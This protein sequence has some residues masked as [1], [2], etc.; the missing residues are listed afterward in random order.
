[1]SVVW[2][3]DNFELAPLAPREDE[4]AFVAPTV[5]GDATADAAD[6]CLEP[7]ALLIDL[8]ALSLTPDAARIAA[9]GEAPPPFDEGHAAIRERM[10]ERLHT[11]WYANL[12]E[13]MAAGVCWHVPRRESHVLR[14]VYEAAHPDAVLTVV[15]YPSVVN[16]VRTVDLVEALARPTPWEV[17]DELKALISQA[18]RTL[19]WQADLAAEVED[20][21]E[22]EATWLDAME[23]LRREREAAIDAKERA[24]AQLHAERRRDDVPALTPQEVTRALAWL[25]EL[26]DEIEAAEHAVREMAADAN[27]IFEPPESDAAATPEAEASSQASSR[28]ARLTAPMTAQ[29]PPPQKPPFATQLSPPP[30]HQCPQQQQQQQQRSL[31]DIILDV[32]YEQFPQEEGLSWVENA[33]KVVQT[34]SELRRMWRSTFGR[35][36]AAS[37]LA[38]KH[39]PPRPPLPARAPG[40][41]PRMIVPGPPGALRQAPNTAF[42]PRAARPCAADERRSQL[43]EQASTEMQLN[44]R[45]D[46]RGAD[47][48]HVHED[49]GGRGGTGCCQSDLQDPW[50]LPTVRPSPAADANSAA[51]WFG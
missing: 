20:L 23:E 17:C 22:R 46:E 40:E 18:R 31:L 41:R 2:D 7:P 32:L 1:M 34:K 47:L 13:L 19:K 44:E 21:A 30:Q 15:H 5:I 12:A 37:A 29:Q 24:L 35:L 42:M 9:A 14:E 51:H 36:P 10:L 38:L 4:D 27:G 39:A 50:Y 8:A 16:G 25:D 48:W 28:D 3:D 45:H 49:G 26:D 6:D 43:G 11:D 33:V